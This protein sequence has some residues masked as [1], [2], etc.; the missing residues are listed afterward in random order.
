[1]S[2]PAAVQQA[3]MEFGRPRLAGS[4]NK[5][6][7]SVGP[8]VAR[9]PLPKPPMKRDAMN[10]S[11]FGASTPTSESSAMHTSA[12]MSM[13]FGPIFVWM[14]PVANAMT[15]P[16]TEHADMNQ[17]ASPR[18]H[19]KYSMRLP[20]AG[21]TLKNPMAKMAPMTKM[22]M[23]FTQALPVLLFSPM[24]LSL[25]VDSPCGRLRPHPALARASPAGRGAR[26]LVL[27]RRLPGRGG[28]LGSPRRRRRPG[29]TGRSRGGR[30]RGARGRRSRGQRCA[31]V[32]A[33][34]QARLA[35][36]SAL[37]TFLVQFDGRWSEAH[38]LSTSF[39]IGSDRSAVRRRMAARGIRCERMP[40]SSGTT[41]FT[42]TASDGSA[43]LCSIENAPS[44]GL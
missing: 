22:R 39:P 29:S 38:G 30:S 28:R 16:A 7:M 3:Q 43:T 20:M 25:L 40:L 41:R 12:A 8:A 1:M 31:A 23:K 27:P 10:T 4:L 5:S 42:S 33:G 36:A 2:D 34:G 18:P 6:A 14:A 37:R 35:R 32:R 21:G 9:K 11:T 44:G 17:P 15:V 19:W 26:R 13:P 24:F